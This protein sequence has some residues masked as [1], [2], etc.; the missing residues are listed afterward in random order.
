MKPVKFR[1]K[2][3]NEMIDAKNYYNAQL[4]DLGMDFI[5]EVEKSIELIQKSPTRW[6]IIEGRK[7]T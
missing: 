2:A 1:L 4:D 6:A 5:D 3:E 7:Y